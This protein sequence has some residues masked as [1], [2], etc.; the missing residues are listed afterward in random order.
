MPDILLFEELSI[1]R[2]LL[3]SLKVS[4]MILP[5]GCVVGGLLNGDRVKENGW[6]LFVVNKLVTKTTLAASVAQ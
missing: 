1:L 3:L 4:K 6:L 5:K 2:S